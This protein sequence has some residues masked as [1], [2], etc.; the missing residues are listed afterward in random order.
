MAVSISKDIAGASGLR[1]EDV[2]TVRDLVDV[3]SGNLEKNRMRMRYYREDVS[4]TDVNIGISLSPG[5][6][7]KVATVSGWP[8]KAV[9]AIADRCQLD[10]FVSSDG[11]DAGLSKAVDVRKL[12]RGFAMAKRDAMVHGLAFATVTRARRGKYPACVHWYSAESAS[13]LFDYETREIRAGLA[14][15]ETDNSVRR[16]QMPTRVNV[17]LADSVIEL[18]K[19]GDTRSWSASYQDHDAGRPLMVTLVNDADTDRP[20][21]SPVLSKSVISTVNNALREDARMEIASEI[22]ATPQKFLLGIDPSSLEKTRYEAYMESIFVMGRDPE[23]G[24]MPA[25]GQLPQVQHSSER[26]REIAAKFSGLT[27]V[28]MAELGY[29]ADSNPSSAEAIEA[30]K[31]PLVIAASDFIADAKSTLHEIC[32]L[33]LAIAAGREPDR[34]DDVALSIDA[35]FANPAK[36]NIV[37]KADAMVKAVSPEG[38]QW[39]AETDVYLEELGFTEEQRVRMKA[40]KS[41][42]DARKSLALVVGDDGDD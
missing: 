13:A 2:Q 3:W 36:A 38:A 1:P 42:I 9:H 19:D 41:R 32:V 16:R 7:E 11:D 34:L 22:N 17:Y 5:M 15:I 14:V 40:E 24:E 37:T 20:F 39:I 21:G 10:G 35:I 18:V 8:K 28:P 30:S 12:R 4:V 33:C 26:A 31:D 27:H 25:Y 6:A 29:S 23:T